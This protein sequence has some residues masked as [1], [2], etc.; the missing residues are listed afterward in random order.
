MEKL[1]DIYRNLLSRTPITFRR[2]LHD[3][4][5]W[6]SRLIVIT[7]ARGVGKTTMML[8]NIIFR[9]ISEVSLYID[10]N[11][12]YFSVN[13]LYDV[14]SAFNKSGGKVL[15][16]DEI[17]KYGDWSREVKMMYDYL[18]DLQ[19]IISGSSML[20][21]K[22][23]VDADLSRRAI[24]YILEGLSFREY[25]NFSLELD[26][27]CYSLEDIIAG[28]I[29]LPKKIEHPLEYFQDYVKNGYYPFFKIDNYPIRLNNIINQTLE[30]D[31][32]RFAK[33][34]ASVVS[35][36]KKLLY[37]ISTS[38]PFK[39]NYSK[40]GSASELDR[41]TV[42]SYFVY[43]EKA[44]LI[45][46]LRIADEGMKLLEKV[47]KVYL[48]NTNLIYSQ[49]FEKVDIGNLRETF[50]FSMMAV[51]NMVASSRA[52]DFEIGEYTFEVGGQSKS[53]KQIKD[54]KNSYIVMDGIEYGGMRTIP[55]WTFGFNY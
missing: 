11:N 42:A 3:S 16:I 51:K 1:F 40:I 48:S 41:G 25:L 12:N 21:I 31:I 19:I 47:D 8:Q 33:M 7:G 49:S 46:Q 26:M 30:V 14:A 37:I 6:K 43:M 13:T 23:G 15:Y 39:P 5:D 36:L 18:P 20:D 27:P 29:E 4:I 22:K 24:S 34:N 44:G 17:H 52:G 38:V 28:K 53:T 55:L 50:F 35:K 32:P 54:V 2:Y 45:R 10:A 9:N